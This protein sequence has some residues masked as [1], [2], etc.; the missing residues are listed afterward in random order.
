MADDIGDRSTGHE[1]D[2]CSS[3]TTTSRTPHRPSIRRPS[4]KPPF[5]RWT[6]LANGRR[7]RSAS[8]A[9][10]ESKCSSE[11]A[12]S[13][14]ARA[15]VLRVHLLHGLPRQL[16]RV[17]GDGARAV[18]RAAATFRPFATT[19][20]TFA[21]TA[22]FG[23][24][25]S[26]SSFVHGL[27]MTGPGFERLFGGPA[28]QAEA[29]LT[30]RETGS[31]AI[32]S[33]GH[34][35]GDAEDGADGARTHRAREAVHGGR[36]RAQL[37]RQRTHSTRG[38]FEDL[39]IQPAAGDAGGALGVALSLAHHH[40]GSAASQ[41]RADRD[42][43]T[44]RQRERRQRPCPRSATRCAARSSVR[45]SATMRSRRGSRRPATRPNGSRVPP[46][47]S[48][49]PRLLADGLVDRTGAGADGVR[50]A[51]ARR[52]VDHRRRALAEDAVGDEP[53]D[54]IP[55]IV[56]AVCAGGA[57]GARRRVV[58]AR[59]REPVHAARRRRRQVA[60]D[61]DDERAAGAVGHREAQRAPLGR[62]RRS[63][64]STIPR[65]CR[66]FAAR[67]IRSSTTSSVPSTVSLAAR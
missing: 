36:R 10:H 7:R 39:W 22:A 62:F 3:A 19:S 23:S 32:D 40:V 37:R 4:R 58:R 51:G 2:R 67:R 13:A 18:R 11:H 16:R 42:V 27:T 47:P 35:R 1:D 29:P 53:Q 65:A 48:A 60:A 59:R 30:Q 45:R 5:S 28:R 33:G 17:Q 64:T 38:T 54:Q 57:A 61:R 12:L 6:A 31:G 66:R 46:W 8:A 56:P 50:S 20:S 24:I 15:A 21:T 41:R 25:W 14:F 9:A 44:A 26:T 63:P 49:W 43:A 34:R 52:A 55:R